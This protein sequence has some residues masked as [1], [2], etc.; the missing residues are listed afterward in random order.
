MRLEHQTLP[1]GRSGTVSAV[2]AHPDAT[3]K[4]A[5][6]VILAH[7]AGSDMNNPF[8]V[9][10]HEEL[11]RA[12]H[13]SVR[14]NFPYKERKGRVPDPQRV[15]E[16]CYRAVLG[17]VR[18]APWCPPLLVIG[19][20][21][22]GG[23]IASHLAA[24]DVDVDGLIFLGYPLH[25]PGQPHKLRTAHLPR[26]EVPMLFLA[27]SRDS[28]CRLELLRDALTQL[29]ARATLH[30][31]TDGDHSFAVPRRAGR[32]A[33]D[34]LGEIMGVTIEWLATLAP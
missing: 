32:T 34:V 33:V 1:D 26:I 18:S 17:A 2:I 16:D 6:A 22:L 28:L 30:V 19:G 24:Q 11:A 21:S 4:R 8:L 27:G 23:R 14:F 25:P 29:Q 5:T 31:I 15:L 12:G 10:V 3:G 7:G 9:R 20:K 13:F